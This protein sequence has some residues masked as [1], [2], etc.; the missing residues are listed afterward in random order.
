LWKEQWER[1]LLTKTVKFNTLSTM[2]RNFIFLCALPSLLVMPSAHALTEAEK[3]MNLCNVDLQK[4]TAAQQAMPGY[5]HIIKT[6]EGAY[7]RDSLVKIYFNDTFDEN[8]NWKT[9]YLHESQVNNLKVVNGEI[10]VEFKPN[11]F[12]KDMRMTPI[13]G[14][15]LAVIMTRSK[16]FKIRWIF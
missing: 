2:K 14:I 16:N 10:N 12:S 1:W 7:L 15:S 9:F 5:A 6:L 11:Y 13:S 3:F 4:F 8:G